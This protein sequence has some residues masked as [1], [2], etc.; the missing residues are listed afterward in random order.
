M[1][2]AAGKGNPGPRA[3]SS[4]PVMDFDAFA[5]RA[6]ALADAYPKEYLEGVDTIDVHRDAKSHPHVP[7]VFTLG[8]CETSPLSDPTGQ[9][10][11]HSIVHLYH[12]S[13]V[14]LAKDD[15]TFDVEA[16]LE[17]TLAHEIQHHLEDRAGLK[18]LRDED[19]LFEAHARFRAGLDVPPGW[20]RWG[21]RLEPG[22]WA[23][24]LDLFLELELRRKEWE[25]LPGTRLELTVLG[26][27]F[28]LDVPGDA[29]PGEIWTFEGEGLV[30]EEDGEEEDG[31]EEDDEEEEQ[32]AEDE[33]EGDEPQGPVGALHV[34]PIVR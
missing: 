1:R 17:E 14:A 30:D 26:Q 8:E 21:D 23:V 2:R 13:F 7:G 10:P 5:S 9:L 22:L 27:P 11:F 12:G 19:D 28:T 25:R 15:S 20:Y 3:V 18:T 32:D 34:I 29:D 6:R 31:E 4:A 33:D 24:D 16:E